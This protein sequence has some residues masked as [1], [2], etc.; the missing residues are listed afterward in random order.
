MPYPADPP[1]FLCLTEM[2]YPSKYVINP[3][4]HGDPDPTFPHSNLISAIR[5]RLILS[6]ISLTHLASQTHQPCRS[7]APA[8]QLRK[9][10]S[11]AARGTPRIPQNYACAFGHQGRNSMPYL[12]TTCVAPTRPLHML[13]LSP[14]ATHDTDRSVLLKRDLR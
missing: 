2:Q 14:D 7:A 11:S 4:G 6:G 3:A 12:Y 13:S 1:Q 10:P 5:P 8:R 9:F